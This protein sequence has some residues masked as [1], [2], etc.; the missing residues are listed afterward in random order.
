MKEIE[1]KSSS[2]EIFTKCDLKDRFIKFKNF[3]K[4][5]NGKIKRPIFIVGCPRSGTTVLGKCLAAHPQIGGADESLFLM[6]MWTIF[7]EIHQGNNKNNFAPLKD[8]ITTED[9]LNNIKAFSDKIFS[10]LL[11]K[12]KKNIYADHTPWYILLAPFINLLY[13]DALFIHIIRDGRGVVNSLSHSYKKGFRWAGKD[14]KDRTQLWVNLV[15]HGLNIKNHIPSRYMEVRYEDFYQYPVKILTEILSFAGLRFNKNT[16]KPLSIPHATPVTKN[17]VLDYREIT[18][19]TDK[20]QR[21]LKLGWPKEWSK[22]DR[23][24]FIL[25]GRD[26]MDKFYPKYK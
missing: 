14:I 2:F 16:L 8:F 26:L 19:E 6:I 11:A 1:Y 12:Q 15:N 20:P 3:K 25:V 4:C 10:R 22:K 18:Q 17:V 5:R 23:Q 24:N 13:P 9:I 7:N 21:V